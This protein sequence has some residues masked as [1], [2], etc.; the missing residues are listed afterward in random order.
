MDRKLRF[1][2]AAWPLQATGT[3][4]MTDHHYYLG[5]C[6]YGLLLASFTCWFLLVA[7]AGGSVSTSLAETT[8]GR[9]VPLP[10][11]L[12]TCLSDLFRF[13]LCLEVLGAVL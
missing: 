3:P 5:L 13:T 11:L 10:L 6:G 9:T 12:A 8:H 4:V 7:C 1:P 2:P